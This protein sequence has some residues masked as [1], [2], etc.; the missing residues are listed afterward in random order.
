LGYAVHH[1][2]RAR[3]C[4]ERERY[5]QAEYWISE[6]R[7][8]ALH[9]A[10]LR[11][12]LSPYQGRGFDDLSAEIHNVFSNAFVTRL[13]RSEL[14][15]VLSCVIDGLLYEIDGVQELANKVKPQL[16]ELS[17]EWNA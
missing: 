8:Y 11:R 12:N 3:F 4:I 6:A 1:V 9:L 5:W 14:M 7:N 10:C 2:L 13:T 15:R 17:A 16:L